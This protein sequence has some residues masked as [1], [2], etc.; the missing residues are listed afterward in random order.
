MA[1]I[2]KSK[3]YKEIRIDSKII[4]GVL[5]DDY[6]EFLNSL[7]GNGVYYLNRD[8]INI[9]LFTTCIQINVIYICIYIHFV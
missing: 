5:G 7:E 9:H 4:N 1:I 6:E 3:K 8:N 2:L